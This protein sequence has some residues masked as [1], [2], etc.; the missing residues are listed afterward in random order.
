MFHAPLGL[1]GEQGH[2]VVCAAR[3]SAGSSGSIDRQPRDVE[4][5]DHDGHAGRPELAGEV[6]GA[7]KL[8]RL[9][10]DQADETAA[11]RR[12]PRAIA[13]TSMTVLHSS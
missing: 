13:W 1:A 12:D 5:A 11:R 8:V 4:A 2:A 7:R 6:D 10:A 9:H 3:R